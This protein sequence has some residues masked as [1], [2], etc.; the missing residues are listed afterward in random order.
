MEFR[1]FIKLLG[2][3]RKRLFFYWGSIVLIGMVIV[4]LLPEKKVAVLSIDIAR[5]SQEQNDVIYYKQ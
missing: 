3:N 4:A 1:K 5:E 2:K